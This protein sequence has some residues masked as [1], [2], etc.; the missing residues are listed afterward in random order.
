V[1]GAHQLG[2]TGGL[3]TRFRPPEALECRGTGERTEHVRL[4]L[5]RNDGL[6][7]LAERRHALQIA[8]RLFQHHNRAIAVHGMA[9][10][11]HIPFAALAGRLRARM[12]LRGPLR[13]RWVR[14]G[15][16]QRQK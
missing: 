5:Q 14:T 13:R 6:A 11:R 10:F 3:Q 2:R 12:I 15:E 9:V 4:F 7:I 16:G 8:L 1:M